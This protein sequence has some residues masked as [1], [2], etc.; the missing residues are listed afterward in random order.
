MAECKLVRRVSSGEVFTSSKPSVP[1]K[2]VLGDNPLGLLAVSV[3][4]IPQAVLD[5][6]KATQRR[7]WTDGIVVRVA[8]VQ[9]NDVDFPAAEAADDK[10]LTQLY[11]KDGASSRV[12][13]ASIVEFVRT[14]VNEGGPISSG[15]AHQHWRNS[16]DAI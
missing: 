11:H 6:A 5:K 3:V 13:E 12:L 16:V 15:D 2:R 7:M 9:E 10:L 8:T 1:D 14:M 4:D